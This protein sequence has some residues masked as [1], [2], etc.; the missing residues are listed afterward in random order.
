MDKYISK[1]RNFPHPAILRMKPLEFQDF[2]YGRLEKE[3]TKKQMKKS[4]DHGLNMVYAFIRKAT[5][6]FNQTLC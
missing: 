1:L 5:V 3:F 2:Q 4:D 6:S